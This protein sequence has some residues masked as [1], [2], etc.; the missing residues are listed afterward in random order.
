MS[1]LNVVS[2]R[3]KLSDPLPH[4]DSESPD[5]RRHQPLILNEKIPL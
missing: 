1:V 2:T 5:L 3:Y 4:I